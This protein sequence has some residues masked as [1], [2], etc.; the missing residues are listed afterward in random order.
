MT[1]IAVRFGNGTESDVNGSN[2]TDSFLKRKNSIEHVFVLLLFFY[3]ETLWTFRFRFEL[4][5]EKLNDDRIVS[6]QIATP[7]FIGNDLKIRSNANSK[8]KRTKRFS[9]LIRSS[10]IFDRWNKWFAQNSIQILKRKTIRFSLRFFSFSPLNK[11]DLGL[12]R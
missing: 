6:T 4:T 7:I 3:F 8:F 9:N 12:H 2:V 5:S 10:L 11:V 1:S